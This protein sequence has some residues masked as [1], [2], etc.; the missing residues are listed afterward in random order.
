MIEVIDRL[1]SGFECFF[2]EKTR[3][4]HPLEV[5]EEECIVSSSEI[6]YIWYACILVN[7]YVGQYVIYHLSPR[8]K[9]IKA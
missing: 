2:L 4:I 9:V 1:R 5:N 7:L 3:S 6:R 8:A